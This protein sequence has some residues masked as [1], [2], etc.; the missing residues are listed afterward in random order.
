MEVIEVIEA[1]LVILMM[2]A[3]SYGGVQTVKRYFVAPEGNPDAGL[4]TLIFGLFLLIIVGVFI[5]SAIKRL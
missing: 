4:A 1:I 5:L 3:L 2:V